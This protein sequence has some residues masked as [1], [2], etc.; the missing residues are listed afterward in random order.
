ML[1]WGNQNSGVRIQKKLIISSI[2]YLVSGIQ[3]FFASFHH[4]NT[5]AQKFLGEMQTK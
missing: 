4:G 5:K 3:A 1:S 2:R